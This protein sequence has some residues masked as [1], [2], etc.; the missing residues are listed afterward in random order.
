MCSRLISSDGNKGNKHSLSTYHVAHTRLG[1]FISVSYFNAVDNPGSE[2]GHGRLGKLMRQLLVETFVSASP[3]RAPS[4]FP[5]EAELVQCPKTRRE[6]SGPTTVLSS[7][8]YL[9][10]PLARFK[11]M[12]RPE[13]SSIEMECQQPGGPCACGVW[14]DLSVH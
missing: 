7:G 6:N 8:V 1:T 11:A 3:G 10:A 2:V 5:E 13:N 9:V 14:F 12:R 4:C